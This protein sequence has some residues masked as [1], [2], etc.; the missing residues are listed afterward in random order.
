[1]KRPGDSINPEE[2]LRHAGW[3]NDLARRLIR[4]DGQADD[5]VQETWLTTLRKPPAI[6]TRSWLARVLRS[7]VADHRRAESTRSRRERIAARPEK[8]ESTP[9]EILD[10]VEM[11]RRVVDLVV[12][13]EEP[14]R[15]TVLLRFFREMSPR[16]IAQEQKVGVTTVRARLHKALQLL[17]VQLDQAHGGDRSAWRGALLPLATWSP[18]HSPGSARAGQESSM[19]ADVA[20]TP[21]AGLLSSIGG[22]IVLKKVTIVAVALAACLALLWNLRDEP[23]PDGSRKES[24]PT[25]RQTGRKEAPS[26]A[27]TPANRRSTGITKTGTIAGSVYDPDGRGVMGVVL[28]VRTPENGRK[29]RSVATDAEGRYRFDRLSAG[30]YE[31]GR[32][33]APV[34]FRQMEEFEDHRTVALEPGADLAGVDFVL[35]RETPLEGWVYRKGLQPVPGAGVQLVGGTD[36]ARVWETRSAEDGSFRFHHL[37]PMKQFFVRAEKDGFRSRNLDNALPITGLQV[38]LFLK[39]GARPGM[40]SGAVVDVDGRPLPD[41]RVLA[42]NARPGL[43]LNLY[44]GYA[45]TDEVGRFSLEGLVA[46]PYNLTVSPSTLP[47]FRYDGVRLELEEGEHRTGVVLVYEHVYTIS[48][49]IVGEDGEPLA[50][51][52]VKAS[53]V[54][55]EV[56][57]TDVHGRYV[58]TRLGPGKYDIAARAP[59]RVGGDVPGIPG[60]TDGV[61]L[62]LRRSSVHFS[63][64]VLRADSRA[65][66]VDFEIGWMSWSDRWGEVQLTSG[67]LCEYTR[68]QAADGYFELDLVVRANWARK[69]LLAARAPGFSTALVV[70]PLDRA[71]NEQPLELH[72]EP[73]GTLR[74][75]VTDEDGAPITDALVFYDRALDDFESRAAA[76]SGPDGTFTVEHFPQHEQSL[77]VLHPEYAVSRLTVENERDPSTPVQIVLTQGGAVEG[78]IVGIPDGRSVT[79]TVGWRSVETG[80]DGT[81]R[82]ERLTPQ[83]A[84]LSVILQYGDEA[85]SRRVLERT[86]VIEDGKTIRVDLR[87]SEAYSRL[88]GSVTV[89]DVLPESVYIKA[90]FT[91]A[92]GKETHL[93]AVQLDGRYQLEHL[94][95]G[96]AE[97]EATARLQRGDEIRSRAE[98]EFGEGATILR[99]FVLTE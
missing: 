18:E 25:V 38:K 4:S 45:S 97:V 67:A 23:A 91:T 79:V 78:R 35:P 77:A 14:Y 5:V 30:S 99:D 29:S 64:R 89:I 26:I 65:P 73:G 68:F 69:I 52:E 59:G 39:M 3:M 46:G 1:M 70:V 32:V 15:S 50:G 9:P 42:Q 27:R 55:R 22:G 81:F 31:I 40:I 98:I 17:R 36:Y 57:R 95:S 82:I 76:K 84:T 71:E 58:L 28:L 41:M 88:A 19:R 2:L 16:A 47:A 72:L 12:R 11:Q 24:L 61:D 34:G 44:N 86:V 74:G 80:S 21:R 62:V 85:E 54:D 83:E 87:F 63:G 7:R 10:C 90:S 93:T 51:A 53:G 75:V 8:V 13:L 6:L 43:Y 66:L 37:G 96:G 48:G 94:P 60:G 33:E 92:S 49:T 20:F 56:V